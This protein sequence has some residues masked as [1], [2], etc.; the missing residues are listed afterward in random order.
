MRKFSNSREYRLR[1]AGWINRL[2][3]SG[4]L[5]ARSG[6]ILTMLLGFSGSMA[7]AQAPSPELIAGGRKTF[8]Q[9]CSF[10]HGPDATGAR[11]PDLVRS[12]LVAHDVDGNLIGEVIHSGRPD[13][14]M[15]ALPLNREQ[16]T[17]IAAFLHDR[18]LAALNSAEVPEQ[19]PL[20]KLLTGNAEAGKEFFN[21][22][23]GC[24]ACHSPSGDLKGIAAKYSPLRLE[25]QML[26]PRE[27]A[28]VT[29]VT[30]A[31]PSGERVHGRLVHLDEFTVALRD[32]SG[33]Y[34]SFSRDRVR[35]EVRDPLAAHQKLLNV[36]T[37]QEVHDL[38][39]YLETLK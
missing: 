16:V 30:V 10:C 12:A 38:F 20:S 18:A 26:Y 8:Q 2:A 33:W 17:A 25:T 31:L 36:L 39:A 9:Y 27:P 23:G 3:A 22:A 14:G 35:V 34:R 13:K 19:Y 29:T 28:A 24:K 4:S 11:G 37:Q 5:A 7:L 21:G 15:P 32:S 1:H 6:F